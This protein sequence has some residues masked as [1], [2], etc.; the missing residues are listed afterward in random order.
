MFTRASQYPDGFNPSHF[1][2]LG[3]FAGIRAAA[4]HALG[5]DDLQGLRVAVQGLG[6]TGNDL[7]G[8]LAEAGAVLT[9]ADVNEDA[10]AHAVEHYGATAVDPAVIHAQDVDVF[11]PCAL[12][13]ILNDESIPELKA[14]AICGLANNQLAEP[15]HGAV[16]RDL[17][18]TY[19]PDYVVNAGGVMGASTVIFTTP[20]REDAIRRIE[21]LYGTILGIL[22]RATP[23]TARRPRSRTSSRSRASRPRVTDANGHSARPQWLIVPLGLPTLSSPTCPR[24]T[25]A[26]A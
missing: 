24:S 17:G 7:A 22:E 1:T 13:G 23:S 19:V 5:R 9:V 16:L 18:I 12:G 14:K 15:R 20:D 8:Q 3:G 26:K 2:A 25:C 6:N 4:K 11:A 21:G 10:V